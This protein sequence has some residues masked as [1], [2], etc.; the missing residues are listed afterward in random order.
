MSVLTFLEELFSRFR[1]EGKASTQLWKTLVYERRFC[2][3]K[4][5]KASFVFLQR[6]TL[7]FVNDKN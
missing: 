4:S 5:G 2:A 6:Q 3:E 1:L 7:V